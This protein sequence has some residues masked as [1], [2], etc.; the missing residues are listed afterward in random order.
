LRL[1]TTSTHLAPC[2]SQLPARTSHLPTRTLAPPNSHPR[3]SQLA[4]SHFTTHA[5][6]SYPAANSIQTLERIFPCTS[7]PAAT[8]IQTLAK[9]FACTSHLATCAHNSHPAAT[10]I[11]TL[12]KIFACTSDVATH[13][14][15]SHTAATIIQTLVIINTA[16]LPQITRRPSLSPPWRRGR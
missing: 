7:H 8:N 10:S 13:A 4:P 14:C 15:N 9:I 11:R 6:N 5:H 12:A 3:T 16:G 1:A 2:D